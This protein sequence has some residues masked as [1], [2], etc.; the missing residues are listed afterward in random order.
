MSGT[1]D[2]ER[3][4]THATVPWWLMATFHVHGTHI[5]QP[6]TQTQHR[7][8]LLYVSVLALSHKCHFWWQNSKLGTPRSFPQFIHLPERSCLSCII[9]GRAQQIR[10]LTNII[11]AVRAQI[12]HATHTIHQCAPPRP[13]SHLRATQMFYYSRHKYAASH[14]INLYRRQ[15]HT[16]V[17]HTYTH[18]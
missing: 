16:H 14:T 3:K 15:A 6:Y 2:A 9:I 8:I 5:I 4:Y 11:K 7:N 17:T 12:L 13:R 10:L 1:Q 18:T